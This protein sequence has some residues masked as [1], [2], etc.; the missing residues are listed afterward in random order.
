MSIIQQ[1]GGGGGGGREGREC[2]LC[3]AMPVLL[4]VDGSEGCDQLLNW[5]RLVAANYRS[6]QSI[7]SVSL[8]FLIED[9]TLGP[10]NRLC[11]H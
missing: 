1:P 4:W 6:R 10:L 2:G 5:H 3:Q 8:I 9:V 11:N 7:C